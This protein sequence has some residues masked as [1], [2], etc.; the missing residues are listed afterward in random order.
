MEDSPKYLGREESRHV[1]QRVV[2]AFELDYSLIEPFN[3]L[4]QLPVWNQD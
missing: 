1:Q 3:L 4:F 2:G